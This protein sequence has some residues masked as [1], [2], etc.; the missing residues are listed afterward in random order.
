MFVFL[1]VCFVLCANFFVANIFFFLKAAHNLIEA[2]SLRQAMTHAFYY[3][4][5]SLIGCA[6]FSLSQ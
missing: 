1:M 5:V 6:S 2:V 4:I 3:L